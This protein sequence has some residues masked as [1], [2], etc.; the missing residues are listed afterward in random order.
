VA[1]AAKSAVFDRYTHQDY[2][3]SGI[4]FGAVETYPKTA[5]SCAVGCRLGRTTLQRM[6][7]RLKLSAAYMIQLHDSAACAHK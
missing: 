2:A 1:S 3:R 5:P 6:M 7:A 4:A